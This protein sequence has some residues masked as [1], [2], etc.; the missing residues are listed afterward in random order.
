MLEE[1][2]PAIGESIGLLKREY[3]GSALPLAA[4]KAAAAQQVEAFHLLAGARLPARRRWRSARRPAS[5]PMLRGGTVATGAGPF[6]LALR[7]ALAVAWRVYRAPA[8]G[9]WQGLHRVY[10]FATEHSSTRARVDDA[11]A[12]GSVEIRTLYLQA[13]LMAVTHPLAFSQA[14]QDILWQISARVRR[15]LRRVRAP[16]RAT[17]RRSCPRTPTAARVR[18]SSAKRHSQW[19]DMSAFC[20]EVDAA[21]ARQRDGHADLMPARGTGIRVSVEMLE[22][23]KRSFGLAAARSTSACRRR[24]RLRTVFGLSSLHFYLAGQRDFDSFMRQAAQHIVHHV[25]R[26]SWA[27]AAHRCLARAGARGATCSTRAWAAT[28]WPGTRPARS[29]PASANWSA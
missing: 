26:A 14:E 3:A 24:M 5:I 2:R 1:L 15:A 22:R 6:G 7:Q 12:G 16:R 27:L 18:A 29:A 17:T 11:L 13:L 4:S 19:L 9:V 23:L 21:L 8:A 28:A 10:R 20:P 25:D